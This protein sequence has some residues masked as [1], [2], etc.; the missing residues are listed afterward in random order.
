MKPILGI[1]KPFVLA[2]MDELNYAS[3]RMLC[4]ENGAQIIFTMM[5]DV[6]IL[7]KMSKSE[8]KKLINIQP[9]EHPIIVQLIGTNLKNIRKSMELVEDLCDGIN[10]N[11]GCVEKEY[12]ERGCGAELLNDLDKLGK[13]ARSM[14]HGTKKNLSFKIRV[15]WD[16]QKI[17]AVKT[18]QTLEQNG[19][20][21]IIVHGRTFHQKYAGKSN[22]LAIKQAKEKVSIPVIANGDV[23]SY[24]SG[25]KLMEK[26]NTD[27]VMVG[28]EVKY[29]PWVFKQES[30]NNKKIKQ[31][32]L[33]Y[34]DLVKKYDPKQD[35]KL[36]QDIVFRMTRD[37]QTEKDKWLIKKQCKTFEE[38]YEFIENL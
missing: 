13:I 34:L 23:T 31:Q 26:T 29:K 12:I 11:V 4:K 35:L 32:L 18:C 3:F 17:N 22:W 33:R 30:F 10:L 19:A 5:Y 1:E 2:P 38:V 28:R 9:E 15:G 7:C 16:D 21:L 27:G 25:L 24:E 36:T 20:D 6:N 8:V 37:F 14:R